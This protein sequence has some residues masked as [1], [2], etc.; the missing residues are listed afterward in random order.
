MQ[1][2]IIVQDLDGK[3]GVGGRPPRRQKR[4]APLEEGFQSA[5]LKTPLSS[6]KNV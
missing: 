2:V 1:D 5:L 6:P 3:A 4:A